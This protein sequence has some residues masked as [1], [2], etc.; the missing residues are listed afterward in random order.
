M[1]PSNVC[2]VEGILANYCNCQ[3]LAHTITMYVNTP[4]D[5]CLARRILRDAKERNITPED[6]IH[7]WLQDVRVMWNLWQEDSIAT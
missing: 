6:N 5:V 7:R 2:I 4:P 1:Y 3:Q